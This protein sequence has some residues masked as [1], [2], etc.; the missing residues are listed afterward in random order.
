MARFQCKV[1]EFNLQKTVK[2]LKLL[3]EQVDI[4]MIAKKMKIDCLKIA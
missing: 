3:F 4:F 2:I 1:S